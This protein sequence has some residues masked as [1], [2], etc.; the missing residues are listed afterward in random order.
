MSI[1]A[2]SPSR[3]D[4]GLWHKTD[5]PRCPISSPLCGV[6][7]TSAER[8]DQGTFAPSLCRQRDLNYD[9]ITRQSLTC[10]QK[11]V[12]LFFTLCCFVRAQKLFCTMGS[13]KR[14]GLLVEFNQFGLPIANDPA[15]LDMDDRVL[16]PDP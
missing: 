1:Q 2:P 6:K 4:V 9:P 7:R 8:V 13:P 10:P 3:G 14:Y 15:F 16:R 5:L 12:L 11:S